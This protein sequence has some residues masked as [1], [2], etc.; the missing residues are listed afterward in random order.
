MNPFRIGTGKKVRRGGFSLV[1]ATFSLGLL[2]F[3]FLSLAPLLSLALEAARHARDERATAQIAQTLIEEGKQGTL[4]PGT[5]YLDIQGTALPS[6]QAAAY[7]AQNT[8]VT[9]YLG[10]ASLTQL[11]LQVTPLGAPNRARF[12][13]AVFPTPA[14]P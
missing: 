12:Y 4:N 7:Q 10:N 3:G 11:K 13:A 5:V 14:A 8:S 9:P 6:A 2:S 1:E